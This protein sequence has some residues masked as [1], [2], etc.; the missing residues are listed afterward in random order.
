MESVSLP[1]Q[2]TEDDNPSERVHRG[3][4]FV[5]FAHHESV[6]YCQQIFANTTLFGRNLRVRPSHGRDPGPLRRGSLGGELGH[7]QSPDA[8]FP[9]VDLRSHKRYS[10]PAFQQNFSPTPQGFALPLQQFGPF[11][12]APSPLFGASPLAAKPPPLLPG[13]A[14]NSVGYHGDKQMN[15]LR[16]TPGSDS[17]SDRNQRADVCREGERQSERSGPRGET[18]TD[19]MPERRRSRDVYPRNYRDEVLGRSPL[20]FKERDQ[21]GDDS[22][23]SRNRRDEDRHDGRTYAYETNRDDE[24]GYSSRDSGNYRNDVSG[25][26]HRRFSETNRYTD[27]S[28]ELRDRKER[29]RLE[30]QRYSRETS[31]DRDRSYSSRDYSSRRSEASK[32]ADDSESS[33]RR[34][35]DGD[36]PRSFREHDL[37]SGVERNYSYRDSQYSR[38]HSR[39]H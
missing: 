28:Y 34:R 20:T 15:A 22:Y 17:S 8:P 37:A 29:D 6:P 38:R 2:Q 23:Q 18:H 10:L 36:G 12:G 33:Y 13:Y 1:K 9:G 4:A 19:G 7:K 27:T 25:T 30:D 11:F 26:S 5:R 39:D 24:R 31:R 14:G 21:Y 16:Q 35:Y 32:Y 3:F